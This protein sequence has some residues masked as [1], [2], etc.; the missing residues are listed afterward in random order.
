MIKNPY[1]QYKSNSVQ[2]VSPQ[3]IVLMLYDAII[4]NV[5]VSVKLI[6]EKDY[7]LSNK[8]IQKAQDIIMELMLSLDK[9]KGGEVAT[10]LEALY[11]YWYRTLIDGN[12]KKDIQILKNVSSMVKEIRNSWEIAMAKE[13]NK[14]AKKLDVKKAE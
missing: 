13:L 5:N 10:N 7:V 8:K 12:I 11:D 4:K 1:E 2:T 14:M 9:E 3:R 6:E